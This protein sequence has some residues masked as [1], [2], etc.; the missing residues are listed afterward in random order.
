MSKRQV[1]EPNTFR[2]YAESYGLTPEMLGQSFAH[3]DGHVYT[4]QDLDI[5]AYHFPVLVTD[6]TGEW[7]GMRPE[8]VRAHFVRQEVSP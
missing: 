3:S 2:R 6:E 7:V 5:D 1:F 8:T 4:V